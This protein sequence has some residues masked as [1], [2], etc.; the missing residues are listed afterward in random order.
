MKLALKL[1]C[2]VQWMIWKTYVSMHNLITFEYCTFKMADV[3][4]WLPY[5]YTHICPSPNLKKI[6]M[7]GDLINMQTSFHDN[8]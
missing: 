6:T 3:C 1:N 2:S 5:A 4:V 7:F 8:S